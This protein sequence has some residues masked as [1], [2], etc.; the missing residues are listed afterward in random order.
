M[1]S[2][3]SNSSILR[4][5][6][7]RCGGVRG[8]W[9]TFRGKDVPSG[10]LILCTAPGTVPTSST[11][12]AKTSANFSTS[13]RTSFR[14]L[15]AVSSFAR[16][17]GSLFCNRLGVDGCSSKLS[18]L[19]PFPAPTT[20]TLAPLPNRTPLLTHPLEVTAP[21]SPAGGPFHRSPA[22]PSLFLGSCG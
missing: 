16:I 21:N 19:R 14:S 7:T 13:W 10:T 12:N 3:S 18:T 8:L 6:Q 5:S 1:M 20:Q 4:L 15:R 17:S 22:T 9:C 2:A 11:A